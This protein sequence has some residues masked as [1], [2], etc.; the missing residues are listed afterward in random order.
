MRY[1]IP[2]LVL[3][4]SFA[5]VSQTN[6]SFAQTGS[7]SGSALNMTIQTGHNYRAHTLCFSPDGKLILSGAYN[8]DLIC[9]F[10][11]D[12]MLIKQFDGFK[13]SLVFHPDG[14]RF[15]FGTR[16]NTII[17]MDLYGNQLKTIS[18]SNHSIEAIAISKTGMIGVTD[19]NND[20][21]LVL[22]DRSGKKTITINT[23]PHYL[24]S[25]PVFTPYG[26]YIV[27][28]T[29]RG[30]VI[31]WNLKGKVKRIINAYKTTVNAIAFSR[32][33]RYMATASPQK[34][35]IL[36]DVDSGRKLRTLGDMSKQK[37]PWW[38]NVESL[39]F[40]PDGQYLV[41]GTA[42]DRIRLWKTDGTL[43]GILA[44]HSS[45]MVR[46]SPDGS[47]IITTGPNNAFYSYDPGGNLLNVFSGIKDF[48][49][50]VI[51]ISK[52][53]IIT[54]G[55]YGRIRIWGAD[56]GVEKLFGND[57]KGLSS[58]VISP[59]E[60][61]IAGAN[62]GKI[63][64]WDLEGTYK[65]R[66]R[67]G[68]TKRV[69]AIAFSP[70]GNKVAAASWDENVY[71]WTLS[72]KL[73]FQ[74]EKLG[75]NGSAIAFS[76][77]GAYLV[78]GTRFGS[79][80]MIVELSTKAVKIIPDAGSISDIAFSS[81]GKYF[82]AGSDDTDLKLW[83]V[84]GR[85]IRTFP[86]QDT[87]TT[88]F[89]PDG[90][91]IVSGGYDERIKVWD[92]NGSLLKSLKG[93][94]EYIQD[95]AFT[96]NGR[97]LI[98]CADDATMR[99]WNTST[100]EQVIFTAKHDEWVMFSPDGYF[101]SSKNGGKL[102][103]MVR[104]LSAYGVDQFAVHK[105]RPDILLKRM[106]SSNASTINYFKNLYKKR[107]TRM[108]LPEK[109]TDTIHNVPLA[110]ILRKTVKGNT[111]DVT[112]ILSD[113]RVPLYRYNIYVNDI[114]LFGARGRSVSE[115][116]FKST[117]RV[118]LTTGTNK[119]EISCINRDSVESYRAITFAEYSPVVKGE[120]YFIG[121]GVS[122]YKDVSL[123]LK[124]AA[125]DVMDLA[126]LFSSMKGN[127]FSK[128]HIKTVLDYEVTPSAIKS[129]ASFLKNSRPEDTLVLF[130]AG[131][132]MYSKGDNPVYY[133]L[134]SN[135]DL[136]NLSATTAPY[137]D[138]EMI[139]QGVPPRNKLF[140]MDTCQ[141]GEITPADQQI[142]FALDGTR[143]ITARAPRGLKLKNKKNAA[144]PWLQKRNR[145]V[146]NDL[147]RRSGAIVFSS[148]RGNE[149]SYEN[150]K[151]ENGLF[152]EGIIRSLSDATK[153]DAKFVNTETL[154][155]EVAT[156]VS[157]ETGGLQNPVIDRD[158]LYQKFR[159][160]KIH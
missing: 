4:L 121:F 134:T 97:G 86:A 130:I 44:K 73:L 137:K 87:I 53:R 22:F 20:T 89:S 135:T 93:H 110:K 60:R 31:F 91:Y 57:T 59:K 9:L 138:V 81:D 63:L 32:D 65:G 83:D 119:I 69:G 149:F 79:N 75:G 114:P 33:G 66:I 96:K 41:S 158:N 133:Y 152:T 131:H 74:S 3:F 154:R 155:K 12:G 47:K 36:W 103:G 43:A 10:S 78:A 118:A 2:V 30:K 160:P 54:A 51:P 72:G 76:S 29:S 11:S 117:A 113:K 56:G 115:S 101:D 68:N 15:L 62:K 88:A 111:A 42:N 46:F 148:S 21:A 107:L 92:L 95:L 70:S 144:R 49:E 77:D 37:V 14:D 94:T 85:K 26:Q 104:G 150:E 82:I 125:K 153:G 19:F 100:W 5:M 156:F 141:S 34:R 147:I 124:Y 105:N 40:S 122:K 136:N 64:F 58:V 140:L 67:I 157:K 50:K 145:Y 123:N 52:N 80:L 128:V 108:G 99:F 6:I 17:V 18:T 142:Y 109:T 48:C 132:G 27:A 127:E 24:K 116:S 35:I 8:S 159:F 151:Y 61:Y 102:V 39:D 84:S 139:L 126:D 23:A 98:S 1:I 112:F 120:L 45:G 28:G 13:G 38:D 106:G 7:F 25:P 90:R 16:D 146:Y 55:S 129:A 71:L 143:G